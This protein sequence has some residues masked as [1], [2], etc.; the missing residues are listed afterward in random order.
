MRLL[1]CFRGKIYRTVFYNLKCSMSTF[2]IVGMKSVLLLSGE[3]YVWSIRGD[4]LQVLSHQVP[5]VVLSTP[6]LTI[7]PFDRKYGPF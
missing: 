5:G 1:E 6:I 2:P 7:S 4:I 3:V